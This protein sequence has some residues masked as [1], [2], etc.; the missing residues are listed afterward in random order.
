MNLPAK[1]GSG[2]GDWFN[3]TNSVKIETSAEVGAGRFEVYIT[4][5]GGKACSF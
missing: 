5:P 1:G 4:G 2:F 3:V